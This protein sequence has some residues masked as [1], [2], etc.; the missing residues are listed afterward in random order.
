ML[1]LKDCVIKTITPGIYLTTLQLVENPSTT[2]ASCP[3]KRCKWNDLSLHYIVLYDTYN[4]FM[5]SGQ[6]NWN[7]IFKVNPDLRDCCWAVEL[8]FNTSITFLSFFTV[9]SWWRSY[10]EKSP[11]LYEKVHALMLFG[12]GEFGN[13]I[14]VG[15]VSFFTF[16]P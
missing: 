2:W 13:I 3:V 5:L 4:I 15:K 14:L 12:A 11:C 16:S 6:Y 7:E 8:V 10:G 9:R 1:K